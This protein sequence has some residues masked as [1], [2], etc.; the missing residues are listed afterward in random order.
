MDEQSNQAKE[1]LKHLEVCAAHPE[2]AGC[3]DKP[4]RK[5]IDKEREYRKEILDKRRTHLVSRIIRKSSKTDV[6]LYSYQNYVTVKEELA[7]LSD[8]FKLI[9][10]INQEMIKLDDNYAEELWFAD[11]DEKVFSFKDKVHYWL[12]EGGE[13]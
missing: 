8:I 5:M 6:L 13:M 4:H 12:R 1:F 10:D 9:E 3:M 2:E 7:Q 11:T